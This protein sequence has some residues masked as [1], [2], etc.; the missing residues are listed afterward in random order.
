M[1]AANFAFD[2]TNHSTR[3]ALSAAQAIQNDVLDDYLE[4]QLIESK[5]MRV[6]F[7]EIVSQTATL[8]ISCTKEV[9]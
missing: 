7:V 6:E 4:E 3:Q 9:Q 2:F 5:I 1:F 8:R